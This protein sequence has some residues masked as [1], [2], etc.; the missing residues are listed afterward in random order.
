MILERKKKGSNELKTNYVVV[1]PL[2]LIQTVLYEHKKY[3]CADLK[4][5]F[6]ILLM[7]RH[8]TQTLN[9]LFSP[10]T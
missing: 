9:N 1:E 3:I 8:C 4:P 5:F 6:K 7:Y 2:F 10:D